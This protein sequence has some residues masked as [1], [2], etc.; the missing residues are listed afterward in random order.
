[1]ADKD[2]DLPS[3]PR[4]AVQGTN[5]AIPQNFQF[6]VKKIPTFTNSVQ[7][8]ALNEMGGDPMD[9]PYALGPNLKL[10]AATPRISS[11]TVTFLVHDDFSDYFEIVKWM[12]EGTPY[13]DFSEVA[14]LK[15]VWH[16]AFLLYLTNKKNPYRKI[17]FR[18]VFPTELSGI[19]FSYAD[20][21]NKN[22]LATVKFTINDYV[23]EEL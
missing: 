20:V 8:V 6:G 16:E 1:M 4:S 3:R 21:E 19:D 7:T 11:F 17:T 18:G 5:L 15:E 9:V 14:P 23:I 13:K 22:I 10:P 2:Y 12:R